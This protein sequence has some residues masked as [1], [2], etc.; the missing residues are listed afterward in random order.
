MV[1]FV[2]DVDFDMR[3]TD[4]IP[5]SHLRENYD[6]H[7]ADGNWLGLIGEHVKSRVSESVAITGP[8]GI[9]R[10]MRYS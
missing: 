9:G 1:T 3:W 10:P 8:A 5:G 2:E 4:V 7:D 6:H